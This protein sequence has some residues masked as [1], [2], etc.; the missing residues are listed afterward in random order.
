MNYTNNPT[1]KRNQSIMTTQTRTNNIT[2]Q[3]NSSRKLQKSKNDNLPFVSVCTPTFN[4]RP[5]FPF[6]IDCFMKQTYP[7]NKME[8]IIVDDGDDKIEE[9]VSHIPQVKYFKSKS[10]LSLGKKRNIMNQKCRGDIIVYM[11]DDDYYPPERVSHAVETLSDNTLYDVAGCD[12]VQ[13]Y[14]GKPESKTYQIG[15]YNDNHAT[16]ATFAF[17]RSFLKDHK[18]NDDELFGEEKS[19]LNNFT[20][21]LVKL[22]ASKTIVVFSHSL[23]TI[24]KRFIFKNKEYHKVKLVEK[25]ITEV[26]TNKKYRDFVLD[27]D[28]YLKD[29]EFGKHEYKKEIVET[30]EKIEKQSKKKL[31]IVDTMKEQLEEHS[32]EE[33]INIILNLKL[34]DYIKKKKNNILTNNL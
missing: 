25:N 19:F 29:Y 1:G 22:D 8:W 15:P 23:N 17:R 31:D 33:L 11:D 27:N 30:I 3:T 2:K 24:D 12:N 5:F 14:F 28:N 26:I 10:K 6:L 20:V 18:Y 32:K 34:Q 21:P 7:L 4:R 9:L 16:A 13:I